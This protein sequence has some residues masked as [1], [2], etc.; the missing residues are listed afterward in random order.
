MEFVGDDV[1]SGLMGHA[2]RHGTCR[3]RGDVP[4]GGFPLVIFLECDIILA[5][6]LTS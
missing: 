5:K 6:R 3:E 4:P 2:A 1:C